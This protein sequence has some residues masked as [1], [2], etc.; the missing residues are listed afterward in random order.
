[1]VEV[2]VVDGLVFVIVMAGDVVV[3]LSSPLPSCSVV[4][5]SPLPS[6]SVVGGSPLP[7]VS[8]AVVV[9]NVA[10]AIVLNVSE[11]VIITGVVVVVTVSVVVDSKKKCN[12]RKNN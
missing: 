7:S 1:M 9:V 3:N 2:C 12:I 5:G 11:V 10:L 6:G 8:L 4:E